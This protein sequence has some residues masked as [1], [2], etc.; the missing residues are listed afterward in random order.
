MTS[1][2]LIDA[3]VQLTIEAG[4]EVRFEVGKALL[5]A[6]SLLAQGSASQPITFTSA[7]S[8]PQPGDWRGIRVVNP[9][10]V[11]YI[12]QSGN[13]LDT[14]FLQYVLIQ[15]AGEPLTSTLGSQYVVDG[16]AKV[17]HAV[18]RYNNGGGIRTSVDGAQITDN[19]FY[20]NTILNILNIL[21]IE[22]TMILALGNNTII[23]G[24]QVVQNEFDF[25]P[26]DYHGVEGGIISCG[27]EGVV[28]KNKI[29][30][31]NTNLSAQ[32][33]GLGVNGAGSV[34][35][36]N[37]I[38]DNAGNGLR[39]GQIAECNN[40]Q[41]AAGASANTVQG[42]LGMGIFAV[43][44]FQDDHLAIVNN[45]VNNNGGDGVALLRGGDYDL[46]SNQII[47]NGGAG[48]NLFDITGALT[49][50]RIEDNQQGGVLIEAAYPQLVF[51]AITGNREFNLKNNNPVAETHVDAKHNWWG[52]T[53]SSAIAMMIIDGQE[54]S[55][56]GIADYEP[57]LM[58][59]I[60]NLST[61]FLPLVSKN[62][63]F[64]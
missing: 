17:D 5:V 35:T 62:E 64:E 8:L 21:P 38:Q 30:Q 4:V 6:G 19:H 18:F 52:T 1:D 22:G 16:V 15:Y 61:V 11:A 50:N 34:A 46:N 14:S 36:Q 58:A 60:A 37:V 42:N 48:V 63:S 53:D 51:N 20:S 2:L 23:S 41:A 9:S 10:E 33:V 45:Q 3:N 26:G 25:V 44:A 40:Y 31:N 7:Q 49:L 54:N 27:N 32:F 56:L 29:A 28:T 47:S 12:E 59:D 43:F 13:V 57:F 39:V 24:N 55:A